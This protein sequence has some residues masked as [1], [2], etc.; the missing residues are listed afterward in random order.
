EVLQSRQTVSTAAGIS[1]AVEVIQVKFDNNDLIGWLGTGL[2]MLFHDNPHP[3]VIPSEQAEPIP[4]DARIAVFGDW[5]TG[6]YGA[7]IIRDTI[8][9]KL[10]RCDVVLHL[11]DT[12]YSGA[13]DEIQE[14]LIDDRP[15]RGGATI[16]RALNGNH[17]MYSGGVGYFAALTSFFKQSA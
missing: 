9:K 13:N 7:P 4:D 10:S 6:L 3:W 16:N 2:R 1:E 15:L 12:Y 17:E 8:V 5:G 14:R 11:G